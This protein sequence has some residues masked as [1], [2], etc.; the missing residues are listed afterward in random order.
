MGGHDPY[1]ASKGCAELLVSPYI[2]SFGALPT[3][4]ARAGNVIGGGDWA[5]DRLVPD[6]ARAFAAEKVLE[7][8]YPHAIRPW[9]HVLEPLSGYLILAERLVEKGAAFE[10]GW[11]FGP[12]TDS[13]QS[14]AHVVDR[15]TALWRNG[16]S[17]KDASG[18]NPH[19]AAFLKLDSSKAQMK[20]GWRPRLTFD[21][22]VELT[23][24][25]YKEDLR[26][27]TISMRDFTVGQIQEF[28]AF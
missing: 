27:P 19:E 26:R 11:N 14:V 6:A 15:L 20:L 4:S 28:A 2:R 17:W 16:A 25:W 22:A 9:Q 12:G 10:G 3:A 1:S 18:E 21:E 5:K 8:R 13:E 7:I 23:V 24:A